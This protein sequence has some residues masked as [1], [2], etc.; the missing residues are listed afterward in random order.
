MILIPEAVNWHSHFDSDGSEG[1]RQSKEQEES[2][3]PMNLSPLELV[4]DESLLGQGEDRELFE[5]PFVIM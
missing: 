4:A 2:L 5:G 1:Y 3:S